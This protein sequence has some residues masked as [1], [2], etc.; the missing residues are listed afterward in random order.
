M[1]TVITGASSGLGREMARQFAARGNDLALCARR[2]DRLEDLRD[3]ISAAHPGIDVQIAEL[4][5]TDEAAVRE[6]FQ[7]FAEHF[8]GLDRVIANAGIG[9]G[10][11]LGTGGA[12]TNRRTITTNVLGMMT[13]VESALEIFRAQGRGHLVVVSSF[14]AV[15]GMRRSM[16][17]YGASKAAVSYLAE[18]LRLERIPGLDVTTLCPGYIATEMTGGENS[19]KPLVTDVETGATAMVRAIEAKKRVAYIP[20]WPWALLARVFPVLPAAIVRRLT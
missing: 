16:T 3:K 20:A 19:T 17:A 8:G 18:G 5:V 6:V 10:A 9:E 2:L 1:T 14:A 4:D 11:P 13:Q 15:R 12:E 7:R